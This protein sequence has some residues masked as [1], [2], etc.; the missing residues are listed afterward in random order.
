ME[1]RSGMSVQ[2]VGYEFSEAEGMH[3]SHEQDETEVGGFV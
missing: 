2:I 3:R 1:N